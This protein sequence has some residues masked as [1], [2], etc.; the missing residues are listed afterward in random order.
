MKISAYAYNIKCTITV[1][2]QMFSLMHVRKM[3][4]ISLFSLDDILTYFYLENN[5]IC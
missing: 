4:Y 2:L 3:S 5:I 1:N